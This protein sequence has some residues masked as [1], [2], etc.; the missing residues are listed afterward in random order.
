MR[1][2]SKIT[3][4][5]TDGSGVRLYCALAG[6]CSV[7]STHA[8]RVRSEA[9]VQ[10]VGYLMY[11]YSHAPTHNRHIHI[12]TKQ[13]LVFRNNYSEAKPKLVKSMKVIACFLSFIFGDFAF[14]L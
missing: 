9:Q 5:W 8:R 7:P 13:K 2:F 11:T 1:F 6:L 14:L 12:I 10:G 3:L 4:G